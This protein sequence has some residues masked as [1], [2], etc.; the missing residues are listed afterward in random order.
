M[1]VEVNLRIS[2]EEGL[3]PPFSG[4]PRCS[5][6]PPE[7]GDKGR[8]RPISKKGSQTPLTPQFVTP[9]LRQ[10]KYQNPRFSCSLRNFL[11]LW[12]RERIRDVVWGVSWGSKA[13][14]IL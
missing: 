9:H 1:G 12:F 2:E 7:K 13:F 6:H 4:F 11:G 14:S 8:F 3:L 10:L 5:S